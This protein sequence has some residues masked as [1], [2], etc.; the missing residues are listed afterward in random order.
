MEPEKLGNGK[1]TVN[2]ICI[3]FSV[4]LERWTKWKELKLLHQ[5]YAS[6]VNSVN[7]LWKQHIFPL[8]TQWAPI[9]AKNVLCG[10][11]IA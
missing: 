3:R 9:I 2:E 8:H 10:K 1:N 11:M 6:E 4:L 5:E 7:S